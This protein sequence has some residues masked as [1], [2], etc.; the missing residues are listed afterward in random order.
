MKQKPIMKRIKQIHTTTIL[1]NII[2]YII[3]TA[4]LRFL[5]SLMLLYYVTSLLTATIKPTYPF[6]KEATM[7][8]KN[9]DFINLIFT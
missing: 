6:T 4:L 5:A 3:R 9:I 8:I 1:L 2:S 7:N